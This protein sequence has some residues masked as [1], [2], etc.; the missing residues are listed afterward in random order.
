[1]SLVVG[2]MMK[3]IMI[4]TDKYFDVD[5]HKQEIQKK[6]KLMTLFTWSVLGFSLIGVMFCVSVLISGVWRL[7]Q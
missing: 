7:I 6:E 3:R 5:K 4:M 2:V 1:M